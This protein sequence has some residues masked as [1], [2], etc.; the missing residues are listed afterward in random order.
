M[1]E[2]GGIND[3]CIITKVTED[4][5]YV[6]LNAGCK[7]TDMEHIKNHMGGFKDCTMEYVSEDERSLIA[8]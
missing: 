8:I 1:N 5:F 7:F 6:V 3:D 4:H 2:K